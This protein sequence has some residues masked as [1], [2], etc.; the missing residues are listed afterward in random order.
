MHN[1]FAQQKSALC[2]FLLA[3]TALS[4]FSG[5]A[6]AQ[7]SSSVATTP[8]I[9]TVIV[10]AS[11][12][13]E[14]I[15]NVP[16]SVT[17]VSEGRINRLQATDLSDITSYV[18]G[19]NVQ[20]SGVD[21]DRLVILTDGP[22]NISPTVGVYVND[23]PFGS[24]IGYALGA[25]FSPDIDPF[26][27]DHIEILR[28][29]QGTLYGASTLGGLVKYVTK[30]PDMEDFSGHVRFDWDSQD[31][32]GDTDAFRAGVNIPIIQDK[33]ALRVSGFYQD[34]SGYLTN[35]R[36]GESNLNGQSKVGGRADLLIQPTADFSIDL[37]AFVDHTDTPNIGVVD[38]NAKTLQPIYGPEAGF[39]F[40]H[41]FAKAD[42]TVFEGTAKYNFPDGIVASSTTSYSRFAVNELADDTTIFQPAF[43]GFLGP[44]AAD[45][46][47][48][49]QCLRRPR[50]LR[51]NSGS[52]RR[53]TI[54]SS[55]LPILLRTPK[56]AII[57]PVSTALFSMAH[58]LLPARA[59]R[60]F[61]SEL[62]NG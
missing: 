40:V 56:S 16:S 6:L 1:R 60:G 18:P 3:T 32:G 25:L 37:A 41:G 15:Q 51:R 44:L 42:A 8:S 48:A 7:A 19:L 57:S 45:F 43:E 30:T 47:F 13:A 17:A 58:R 33:V 62:R 53:R 31:N 27:L 12:R 9:E 10:T 28:G 46:E 61:A 2:G 23:A 11:K 29:P 24:N 22:N 35:E 38:G 52:P 54:I 34:A 20:S 36:T 49:D 5:E 4:A 26:D 59:A 55:G 14:N 39:D 50:N 21:A